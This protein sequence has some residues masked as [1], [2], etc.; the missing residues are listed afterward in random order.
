[1]KTTSRYEYQAWL[2]FDSGRQKI[3]RDGVETVLILV[4]PNKMYQVRR[5]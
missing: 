4:E 3:V 1:M 5:R 2:D